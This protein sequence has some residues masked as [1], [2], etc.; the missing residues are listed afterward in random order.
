VEISDFAVHFSAPNRRELATATIQTMRLQAGL[1]VED[2]YLGIARDWVHQSVF[3]LVSPLSN[4]PRARGD[5]LAA[6][7]TS[8]DL[9]ALI[10]AGAGQI[11]ADVWP[12]VVADLGWTLPVPAPSFQPIDVMTGAP[13]ALQPIADGGKILPAAPK[14]NRE[15]GSVS[16][17]GAAVFLAETVFRADTSGILLRTAA[18]LVLSAASK[19]ADLAFALFADNPRLIDGQPWLIDGENRAAVGASL[20]ESSLSATLAGL[21]RQRVGELQT[22]PAARFLLV[23]PGDE[24]TARG[25]IHDFGLNTLS[26]IVDARLDGFGF[27]VFADPGEYPCVARLTLARQE[28]PV[29]SITKGFREVGLSYKTTF[30]C[31]LVPTSRTG[32]YWTPAA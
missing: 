19:L 11:L 13:P 20:D 22:S 25:L 29:I 28:M 3:E 5:G 23:G 26:L 21:R 2:G 14:I 12:R 6:S 31:R 7:I 30:D 27:G 1:P 18:G 17:F 10:A 9:P 8:G 24:L 15:R 16:P 4:A 32:V